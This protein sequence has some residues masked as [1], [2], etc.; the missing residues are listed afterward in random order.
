MRI[1][2]DGFPIRVGSA[3]IGTYTMELLGALTRV[4]PEHEYYLADFG[5]RLAA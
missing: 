4:A 2:V 5:P 1:V 3:G